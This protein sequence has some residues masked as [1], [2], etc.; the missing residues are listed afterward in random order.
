[1]K[2]NPLGG[3]YKERATQVERKVSVS[4]E[5]WVSSEHSKSFNVATSWELTAGKSKV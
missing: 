5:D 4:S 2:W 3:Q 1:L